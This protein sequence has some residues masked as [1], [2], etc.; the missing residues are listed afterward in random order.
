VDVVDGGEI[1]ALV[2][3]A[4]LFVGVFVAL[5]AVRVGVWAS[6]WREWLDRER[7]GGAS[8]ESSL[9]EERTEDSGG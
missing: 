6:L 5:I 9:S 7:A 3:V 2:V 1:A 4:V 8:R